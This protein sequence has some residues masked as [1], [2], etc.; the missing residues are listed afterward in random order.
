MLIHFAQHRL[1]TRIDGA[2]L[3]Y[4]LPPS[5]PHLCYDSAPRAE[6][7]LPAHTPRSTLPSHSTH[8]I[9][10][11]HESLCTHAAAYART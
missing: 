7:L 9:F 5:L 3:L 11:W 2:R 4:F 1:I 6:P 8:S 10:S